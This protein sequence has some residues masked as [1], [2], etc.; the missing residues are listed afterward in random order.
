MD[1]REW[2]HTVGGTWLCHETGKEAPG[3]FVWTRHD[4]PGL[5]NAC[6][7]C[8]DAPVFSGAGKRVREL[9]KLWHGLERRVR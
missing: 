7:A 2:W 6:Y 8:S 4:R 1:G 5:H 9:G 3:R